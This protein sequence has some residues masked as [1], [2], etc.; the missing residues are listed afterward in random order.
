MK[1]DFCPNVTPLDLAWEQINALGGVPSNAIEEAQCETINQCL[2]II[3]AL[4]GQDPLPIRAA[5]EE[6]GP[7]NFPDTYGC[8]GCECH[9]SSVNS[10]TIDPPEPIL[11][12][13]CPVHGRRDVDAMND[14]R[15][16]DQ[17]IWR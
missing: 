9:M 10:A 16:D 1:T 6:P 14:A 15:R 7:H 2:A 17:E 5:Y 4:G 8:H 12:Q 11:N 3:E 13:W